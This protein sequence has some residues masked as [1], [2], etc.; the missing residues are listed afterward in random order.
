VAWEDG[1]VDNE[2]VIE[3]VPINHPEVVI[4]HHGERAATPVDGMPATS[5]TQGRVSLRTTSPTGVQVTLGP[6][7]TQTSLPVET[8]LV[9]DA[10]HDEAVPLRFCT[11]QNMMEVGLALGLTQ[12]ELD[13][14]L[15]VVNTEELASFQE[16]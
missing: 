8:E 11:L 16:A 5:P 3:Y 2:F 1:K 14:D 4:T 6:T 10:D 13:A 12:R 7:V 9:L 15:L